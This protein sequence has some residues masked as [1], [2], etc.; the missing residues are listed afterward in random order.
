M[1]ERYDRRE[2][3]PGRRSDRDAAK[4][5]G[6]KIIVQYRAKGGKIYELQSDGAVVI[7][8]ICE[9]PAGSVERAWRVDAKSSNSADGTPIVDG[10]GATAADALTEVARAWKAHWPPLT[11]FDWEAIAREL[12]VVQAV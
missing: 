2:R 9:D 10:W 8:H 12:H 6:P 3:E 1:S 4:P 5:R 11:G 7:V